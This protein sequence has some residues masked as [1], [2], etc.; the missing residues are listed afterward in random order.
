[1]REMKKMRKMEKMLLLAAA[2]MLLTAGCG[3]GDER[4]I[5]GAVND[6][7]AAD[8]QTGET[9]ETGKAEEAEEAGG[10]GYVFV[11]QDTAV[12]VDAD[13]S[14]AIEELGDPVSYYEAASCA[15]GGL[16]KIYTYSHFVIETYP[17]D[18]TDR[19]SAVIL[20]DD[21]VTTAEGLSIGDSREKLEQLYGTESTE[22]GGMLVYEKEGMKLC[23]IL[24]EDA[25]ASIEYRTMVL[26]E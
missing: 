1:M 7:A 19:V 4:R 13:V 22:E 15:F 16:D 18:G 24:Q 11:W 21:S 8:A 14:A 9:A 26:D 6:T 23:F 17:Q 12:E 20:K 5:E 25:V 3:S 2:C 10:K